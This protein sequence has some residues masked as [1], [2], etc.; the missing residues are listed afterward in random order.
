M[1]SSKLTA[2]KSHPGLGVS[3]DEVCQ[4]YLHAAR[5]LNSHLSRETALIYSSVSVAYCSPTAVDWQGNGQDNLVLVRLTCEIFMS[6]AKHF[7]DLPSQ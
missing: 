1:F 6:T 5:L 3:P 4:E 2:M 7:N